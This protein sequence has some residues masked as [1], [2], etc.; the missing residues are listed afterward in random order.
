[1]SRMSLVNILSRAFRPGSH[2]LDSVT[3]PGSNAARQRLTEIT[4]KTR[5]M[6]EEM[7]EETG[8]HLAEGRTD[9][10]YSESVRRGETVS[11]EA[12]GEREERIKR[13]LDKAVVEENLYSSGEGRRFSGQPPCITA[14]NSKER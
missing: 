14:R 7:K 10:W 6:R 12:A 4:Q 9:D 1:M 8:A 2:N 3:P 5:Q 11:I 13:A